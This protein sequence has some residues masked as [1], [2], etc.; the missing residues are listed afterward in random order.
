VKNYKAQ[1]R[2]SGRYVE[3]RV[4]ARNSID[5]RTMLEGQYGKGCIV[6]G[7]NEVR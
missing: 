4:Q 7:P 2:I 5:A 6:I 3:V 1:V